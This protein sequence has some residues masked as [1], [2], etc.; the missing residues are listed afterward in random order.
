MRVTNVGAQTVLSSIV[1]LVTRGL[2]QR[3]RWTQFGDALAARFVSV[4]LLLTVLTAA[5]WLCIDADK[6]FPAALAVLVVSCPC[7]FALS[8]PAA[9]TRA[10]AVLARRGVLVLKADALEKLL[11]LTRIVFDKTGTL[12]TNRM[13]LAGVQSLDGSS[14]DRALALAA[15]LEQ[16]SAH[17]I[18]SAIRNAAQMLPLMRATHLH[19][20]A[21]AGIEGHIDGHAYRIG[22]ASFVDPTRAADDIGVLLADETGPVACFTLRETLRD[23][24]QA[25]VQALRDEGLG[26]EILSGDARRPVEAVAQRLGMACQARATPEMKLAHLQALRNAGDIVAMIGDGVNDA[27]VLAGADLAIALG[28]GAQLAQ[29]T[30]DIVL[31]GDRLAALVEARRIAR[32][33]MR[34]LRQNTYWAIV[35][36]LLSIPLAAAGFVPPWLAAIGMS[37][38]SLLVVLNSLRIRA[39]SATVASETTEVRAAPAAAAVTA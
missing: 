33:T 30:A 26:V 14:H 38:S 10:V 8:V 39:P 23:D 22:R 29:S 7:A 36:N 18:A 6:A 1:R 16:S 35:Y 34:V 2:Q 12:T 4:I 17:P 31:A 32:L 27:P 21:G 9:M 19:S 25:T 24:A 3:P 20:V 13:E 37:A 28:D 5:T 15:S 11:S